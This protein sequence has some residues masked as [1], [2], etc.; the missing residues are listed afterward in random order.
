MTGEAAP[1]ENYA[2][3]SSAP[4]RTRRHKA[5]W[6]LWRHSTIERCRKCGKVSRTPNG[7]VTV[8]LSGGHA[9][10]AGL[11]TCGSVW[12]CP[13]C[14]AKIAARRSLEVGSLLAAA[15]AEGVPAAMVTL[16]LRHRSDDRLR[17]LV[18][19]IGYGWSKSTSGRGWVRDRERFGVLG[20]VRV[21]EVT[22]GSRNGWHPHV[23]AVVLGEGLRTDLD[24]EELAAG[25][26]MR[27]RDAIVRL[28]FDAPMLQ[29][30][31]C[32]LLG[33]QSIGT[34]LAE[35]FTL[36]K[37]YG[38]TEDVA[39]RIG[40]EMTHTQSKTARS[41]HSTRSVWELLDEANNGEVPGVYLWHE[42]EQAMKG[43]R[44]ISYSQG[45]RERFGLRLDETSDEEIA[46]EELGDEQDDLVVILPDGWSRLVDNPDWI[47]AMLDVTEAGGQSALLAFLR[48]RA[49][50]HERV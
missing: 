41:V 34:T 3:N 15:Q 27:W 42:F 1:L 47:P 37:S 40:M 43:K 26:F 30:Q 33:G 16:T 49:V 35:Y 36:A 28:G 44:Q 14:A 32:H 29:A 24:A 7:T 48:D 39:A 45:I 11:V 46:E 20:F 12:A 5:R 9:G 19:A 22:H 13:V 18:E 8:R 50:S 6:G 31:E 23:H 4:G 25:M 2:N 38:V 17:P 21:Q 10:L